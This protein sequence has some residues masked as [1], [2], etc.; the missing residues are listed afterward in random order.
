MNLELSKTW[1]GTH[2]GLPFSINHHGQE[3]PNN[4]PPLNNGHGCWCFYIH[5]QEWKIVNLADFW[6]EGKLTEHTPGGS[7]FIHYDYSSSPLANADWNGGI[8]FW[9]QRDQPYR[10]IKVGCDFSHIWDAD[11]DYNYSLS[12]IHARV[13]KCIDELHS[14]FVFKLSTSHHD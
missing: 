4:W 3:R 1:S 14:L 13:I 8:T 7:R 10:T 9:E 12:D 6:L 2:R 11:Y 5:I